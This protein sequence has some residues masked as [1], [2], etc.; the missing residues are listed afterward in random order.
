MPEQPGEPEVAAALDRLHEV[1]ADFPFRDEA[2]RA[3]WLSSLLTPLARAAF[4]GPAPLNLIDANVR[5]TG[6]SLLADVCSTILTGRS[7]ARMSYSHDEDE[8]R[9]QITSIALEAAQLVLIDNVSGVFGSATLDR[10]LTARAGAPTRAC[11]GLSAA[12]GRWRDVQ[13]QAR[14]PAEALDPAPAAPA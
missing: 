2:H 10:V 8:I 3:A 14:E 12:S 5:G 9:K 6:K 1:V 13:T 11:S 4:R 7:A